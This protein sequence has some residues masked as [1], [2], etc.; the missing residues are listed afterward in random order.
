M[1]N[2][3]DKNVSEIVLKEFL[4][5]FMDDLV[6]CKEVDRQ[7]LTGSINPNT[8]ETV[9]FK[10]PHQY[11]V[12][13]TP[14]GDISGGT[15]SAL[16]SATATARTS[17]Y[18]TIDIEWTQLEQAIKLNQLDEVLMPARQKMVTELEN[19]LATY[20]LNN[21]GL[22]LG[23]AGSA[24]DAW[25]DI[26][27]TGSYLK[28]LGVE[29]E[30]CAVMN[31][32]AAQDLA[33]TQ[34]GLA[35]GDNRLVTTAWERAQISRPFGGV[36]AL[37]SNSLESV[38]TGT[39]TGPYVGGL[40]A[41]PTV[42]YEALKDTYQITVD[43]TIGAGETLTAGQQIQ[44]DDTNMLQQQNKNVLSRRGAA[45]PFVG[46]VTAD[47]TADGAGAVQVVLSGA[48]IFDV[49]NPQYNTVDRAIALGDDITV[50]GA[51]STTYQP[52]LF[53]SKGYVGLGTVELPRLHT[54]DSSVVNYDGFSI[55]AT[56]YSDPKTNT[57]GMRLD[58]L[59]SF[60]VFNPF[61][62]GQFFG[63]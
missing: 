60:C 46:T 41:T 25:G 12:Q 45:I 48:P 5:G 22:T 40:A 2:N 6:L 31:P 7:M 54:W 15:P 52:G 49:A 51:A 58:M 1:A 18:I 23:T 3:L 39:A 19:E 37:M 42:T 44:F 21:A 34:S 63:N 24:I 56:R 13:R 43:L 8:G 16:I 32:W 62:G 10:R 38:L 47:A 53:F 30:Y 26:A 59:P 33:D 36:R 11:Q 55:R 50:L 35:S 9:Q 20:M 29:D 17:E 28:A 57:Q 27:G 61:M 14:A 4:P